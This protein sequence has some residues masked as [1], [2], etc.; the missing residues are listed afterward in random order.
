M[1][2][3]L[4]EARRM[5]WRLGTPGLL[6]AV[7]VG[8][9][10]AIAVFEIVPTARDIATREH[11]LDTRTA[12][13]AEPPPPT[14]DEAVGPA[15]PDQRFFV[16]LHSFHAIALK[17][18]ISIPQVSYEPPKEDGALRRYAVTASF[19]ST[20]LQLRSFFADLRRL[21]GVRCQRV[22]VSRPD[23]GATQLDVRIQCSFL[24]EGA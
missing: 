21:P 5:Q 15:S 19:A 13:L 18:G 1:N 23:I 6:A 16:F 8:A 11:E 12:K 9:V 20:Y 22:A 2:R 10:I 17:N 7:L 3:L 4:W 24:V 14:P